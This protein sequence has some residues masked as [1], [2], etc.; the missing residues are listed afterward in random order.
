MDDL[1]RTRIWRL[2]GSSRQQLVGQL[3]QRPLVHDLQFGKR[4]Q[5][6]DDVRQHRRGRQYHST[7]QPPAVPHHAIPRR[8][9]CNDDPATWHVPLTGSL[10]HTELDA[11]SER[12]GRLA[13]HLR[14]ALH[15]AWHNVRSWQ[16][17]DDLHPPERCRSRP[18][19][20]GHLSRV[21]HA[22]RDR[23]SQH[24]DPHRSADAEP[25]T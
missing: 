21:R 24:S 9:R 25:L 15:R 18:G 7:Q 12:P 5:R 16:R 2:W 10:N 23:R 22:R 13:Y 17:V 3:R 6:A 8:D 11:T 4:Q 19:P 1:E 14:R 20:A